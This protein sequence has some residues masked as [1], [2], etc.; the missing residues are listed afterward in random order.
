MDGTRN[1][2]DHLS[3]VISRCVAL[4]HQLTFDDEVARERRLLAVGS[5]LHLAQDDDVIWGSGVNGKIAHSQIIAKTLDIRAVRGPKTAAVLRALG[6]KVPEV[7]GDPALLVPRYFGQ[8]F[9]VKPCRD[10]VFIPN[11]NDLGFDIECERFASPLMGWNR[12]LEEIV[13]ARL[14]ISSSLHGIV[15]AEAFGVPARQVRLSD[16]EP[17]FKYDDYALGTGRQCLTPARSIAEAMELGGDRPM[18]FDGQA[19]VDAFPVDLWR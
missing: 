3:R 16:T 14:V 8:R 15:L 1:F 6:H 4:E 9:V 7:Y 13:S 17:Q 18:V 19:L 5:I 11:L 2:G 12:C 10:Y